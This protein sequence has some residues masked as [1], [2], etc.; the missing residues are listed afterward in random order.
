MMKSSPDARPRP[1]RHIPERTCAA[2]RNVKPKRELIRIVRTPT[3]GVLVDGTGKTA[4]RGAYLC[5][6]TSCWD[7]P[8]KIHRLEYVLRTKLTPQDKQRLEEYRA[9]LPELKGSGGQARL[10]VKESSGDQR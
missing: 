7:D 1:E 9:R 5:K 10:S 6:A 8:A 4:G 2:C 3:A